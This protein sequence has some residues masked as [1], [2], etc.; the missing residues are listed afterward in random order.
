[1]SEDIRIRLRALLEREREA[2]RVGSLEEL[3]EMLAEK[4]ALSQALQKEPL[5]RPHADVAALRSMAEENATLLE[6]AKRGVQAA[7]NRTAERIRVAGHL[8][9]YDASGQ[10]RSYATSSELSRRA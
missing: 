1:M 8:D 2:L 6:A 5:H 10:R 3:G 9:T 4:Q 7:M